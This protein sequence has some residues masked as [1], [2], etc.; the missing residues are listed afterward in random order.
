MPLF[1][2]NSDFDI[3][4]DH[5]VMDDPIQRAFMNHTRTRQFAAVTPGETVYKDYILSPESYL[6]D[7]LV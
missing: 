1:K 2:L 4:Q 6:I 7:S 5:P 3:S